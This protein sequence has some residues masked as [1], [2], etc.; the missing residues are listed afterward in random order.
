MKKAVALT[1]EEKKNKF[2]KL[3]DALMQSVLSTMKARI[4]SFIPVLEM[5]EFVPVKEEIFICTDGEKIYYNGPQIIE[6][7]KRHNLTFVEDTLFHIL[8]HGL[9]G[10]FEET[11]WKDRDLAWAVQDLQVDRCLR[12][13]CKDKRA[14]HATNRFEGYICDELYY[15]GLTDKKIRKKLLHIGK[16]IA[17]ENHRYWYIK[18]N[19]RSSNSDKNGPAKNAKSGTKRNSKSGTGRMQR[20]AK[21]WKAARDQLGMQQAGDA[22][23]LESALQKFLH[24]ATR[25]RQYGIA[26]G[27]MENTVSY[28]GAG[29][30]TYKELLEKITKLSETVKEEQE[31]DKVLYQYGLELYGDVPIVEPEEITDKKCLHTIVV[32]VDTSG[33]CTWRAEKFFQEVV[34]VFDEI[35]KVGQVEHICYLECDTEI[36]TEKNYYSVQEFVNFGSTHTFYGGGGTDFIPVFRY[37]DA[38]VEKG[39]Q[40]DVLLYITDACGR[41]PDEKNVPTYPVYIL[42]DVTEDEEEEDDACW[43][44]PKWCESIRLR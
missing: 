23:R 34:A 2:T 25:Q 20:V 15:K 24:D 1:K 26:A 18:S 30:N 36:T 38:L 29:K 35:K 32:A 41:F 10:H 17:C 3:A 21:L 19:M 9:L 43:G 4:Y 13:L 33:S 7:A 22:A 27:D 44:I 6:E 11:Y 31:L 8:F 28:K 5:M 37:T 40:V 14:F 42:L 16:V 12:T 39:E